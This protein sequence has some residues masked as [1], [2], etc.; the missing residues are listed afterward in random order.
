MK[1]ESLKHWQSKKD[2]EG[3]VWLGF[4]YKNANNNVLAT[5]ALIQLEQTLEEL[6]VD[7]LTGL[8]IYSLKDNA[9]IMGADVKSFDRLKSATE[10][11][12]L[13]DLGHRV[14]DKLEAISVPT[15]ALIDGHCLG[16][17]L[18]L[19]LCCNFLIARSDKNLNLG[20]PEVKLG[21]HPGFG[22]TVRM[23]ERVGALPALQA[24]LSGRN[25]SPQQ[26][27]KIGLVDAIVPQRHL[28]KSAV[29]FIQRHPVKKMTGLQKL[30]HHFPALVLKLAS[31]TAE[32]MLNKRVNQKH[33]PAPYRL[34]ELWRSQLDQSREQKMRMEK[35]SVADLF[36]DETSHNLVRVFNLRTQ[37]T[38]LGKNASSAEE[39]IQS[40]QQVHVI[41]AGV[42]GGDIATW[43]AM[44]GMQVTL[45]DANLKAL[46]SARK[47][48]YKAI[49][50]TIKTVN[51]R[52]AVLDRL[53]F[54][55]QGM[56][57]SSA[58]LV[59]EAIV[60]DLDIK[61]QLFHEVEAKVNQ[62][63]LIATNTSSIPLDSL[64]TEMQYPQ[65]FLGLHFFNPVAKMPLVEVIAAST[66]SST[67]LKQ[68][69]QFTSAI[70]RLP[71]PVKSS[72]GFLVN[73][74]LMA[75]L[76]EA[77]ILVDEGISPQCIDSVAKEF[78]M[79][80]GPV[81]LADRVGLDICHHVLHVF[82]EILKRDDATVKAL[83]KIDTM[84]NNG[85]LG[86]KSGQGFYTY[87]N[88]KIISEKSRESV[89]SLDIEKRLFA[90]FF[91]ECVACMNESVVSSRDFLDA[92]MIFGTGFAPFRGGPMHYLET[93][94]DDVYGDL[95]SFSKKYGE[96]FIPHSG[97]ESLL[98]TEAI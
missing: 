21:I 90:R 12:K 86:M 96:R 9:F 43:C 82:G 19:S 1:K 53:V 4:D 28:K 81:E 64:I 17:G 95:L 23:V 77:M 26:A 52:T 92:G 94:Y 62:A 73:R 31:K 33:Y 61:R 18:E 14:C 25:Y 47:R 69:Y 60:E 55:P 20:L 88:G 59:I 93:H 97:W 7:N 15:V 37:L 87:K 24:I 27:K 44:R 56:G 84:V 38:A 32:K 39:D 67:V 22:G 68:A 89:A 80:M 29:Y 46:A 57:L 66:T 54:D 85:N 65:R 11:R 2:K 70:K 16:G 36:N 40:I 48:S 41:G 45:Q 74:I 42:M 10:A 50:H 34:L 6:D 63:T 35:D 71:L 98:K 58:S 75:Y 76:V 49:K 79:P 51:E 13:V 30:Q 91:N 72:I 78:G 83:K 8:V 5:E 3:I